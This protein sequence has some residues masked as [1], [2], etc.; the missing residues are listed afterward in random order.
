M[1]FV[2]TI[3]KRTLVLSIVFEPQKSRSGVALNFVM[4]QH[5]DLE[6]GCKKGNKSQRWIKIEI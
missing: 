3:R 1:T 4:P 2:E 6:D 5:I